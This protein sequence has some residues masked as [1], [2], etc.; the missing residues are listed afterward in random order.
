MYNVNNPRSQPCA[1][2]AGPR[3]AAPAA[4]GFTL[5][6]LLI[7]LLVISIL[8]AVAVFSYRHEMTSSSI[9]VGQAALLQQ[10]QDLAQFAQDHETYVGGCSQPVSATDW[11]ISCTS[12]TQ[13]GFTIVATGSGA[14]AGFQFTLDQS[15][16]RATPAAPSG[17]PTSTSCWITD[18]SGDC[19]NG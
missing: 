11:Q 16:A 9:K 14:A 1:G 8:T 10:A 18:S 4:A 12:L 2:F 15:G 17:W 5:I 13:T 3:H 7:A 19:A 6:E